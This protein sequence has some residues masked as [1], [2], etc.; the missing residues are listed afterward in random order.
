M[1]KYLNPWLCFFG[2]S[3]CILCCVLCGVMILITDTSNPDY[4]TI[5]CVWVILA[6][7][8]VL[9]GVLCLPRWGAYIEISDGAVCYKQ[10]FGKKKTS[11]ISTYKYAYKAYYRNFGVK[12]NFIV[13]S[14]HPLNQQQLTHINNVRTSKK[15][16]KVKYN[17]R[18]MNFL[19][20][21]FPQKLLSKLED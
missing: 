1:K 11:S 13:I 7:L 21:E 20:K 16:I 3:Y 14:Q 9:A 15:L 10:P 12:R 2:I 4:A 17:R 6:L 8:M 19:K 5:V 18:N